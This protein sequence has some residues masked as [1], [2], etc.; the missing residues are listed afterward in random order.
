MTTI[1][2]KL[3]GPL[4]SYG[5]DSHFETRQTQRYPSKSAVI[6]IIAASLGLRRD[7]DDCI[8]KLNQL[9]FAIRIDQPGEMLRDYHIAKST[10]RKDPYVTNRYYLQDAVFVVA[11]S[12]DKLLMQ[13]I[14]EALKS[15]YFQPF[16]GR[17]SLPLVN[18]FFCGE[19][20]GSPITELQKLEWQSAEWY[21]KKNS[22]I[23]KLDIYADADLFDA[24][25]ADL[26]DT[27][28]SLMAR[29]RVISFSQ[30]KRQHGFR[31]LRHAYIPVVK[32]E[33]DTTHDAFSNIKGEL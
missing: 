7:Q 15:P 11:I 21:Q 16:M 3:A 23:S 29:D 17:R 26:P 6:G 31:P 33:K 1:L 4:Q 24:A 20:E 25:N 28:E 14:S 9:S 19:F 13:R 5:I 30:L 18:D 10:K 27:A 12:G 22:K 8:Q 32:E 2:L